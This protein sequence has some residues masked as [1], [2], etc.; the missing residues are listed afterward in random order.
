MPG[1]TKDAGTWG[2][3]T[4][5]GLTGT[6]SFTAGAEGWIAVGTGAFG[7]SETSFNFMAI[8][9]GAMTQADLIEFDSSR[10][11]REHSGNE[12]VPQHIW[13]PSCIYLG[14]TV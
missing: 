14:L 5:R 1:Q 3:D 2:T 6:Q 8:P 13:T 12:F 10:V 11:W 9:G 7:A 4:G